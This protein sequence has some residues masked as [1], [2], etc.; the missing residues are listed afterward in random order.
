LGPRCLARD[1]KSYIISHTANH[2]FEQHLTTRKTTR[3]SL[4]I[5]AINSH[6]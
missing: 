5:S 4:K 3:K 6:W 1:A 2:R